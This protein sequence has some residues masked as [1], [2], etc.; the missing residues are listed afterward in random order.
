[1]AFNYDTWGGSWGI[2]SSWGNSWGR[3]VQPTPPVTSVP[4]P[5]DGTM[6]RRK[7]MEISPEKRYENSLLMLLLMD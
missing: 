5:A 4:G 1:M 3:S 7:K 6:D 2:P